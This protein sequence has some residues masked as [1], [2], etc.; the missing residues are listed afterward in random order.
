[1]MQPLRQSGERF[2]LRLG[3]DVHRLLRHSN[4]PAV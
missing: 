1:V 2:G 4:L 3:V